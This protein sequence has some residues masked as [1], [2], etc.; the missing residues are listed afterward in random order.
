MQQGYVEGRKV[1]SRPATDTTKSILVTT[2]EIY[3]TIFGT[4]S[5]KSI[6][7]NLNLRTLSIGNNG[8]SDTFH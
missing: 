8:Y 5:E 1:S 6:K 3:C 4:I 2:Y 7:M